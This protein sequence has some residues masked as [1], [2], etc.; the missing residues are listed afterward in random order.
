VVAKDSKGAEPVKKSIQNKDGYILITVLLMLLVLTVIGLAALG[1][2][3][4]ENL[5]S[6]NIRLKEVNFAAADG[7]NE[8]GITILQALQDD[9]PNQFSNLVTDTNL[10]TEGILDSDGPTDVT[11]MD[12][13]ETVTLDIDKINDAVPP[14]GS[15]NEFG[16]AYEGINILE[17]YY[18]IN[19]VAGNLAGSTRTVGSVYKFIHKYN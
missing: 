18:R 16:N 9:S 12:G 5:M 1:T 13:T 2:S 8:L 3:T 4:V 7:C 14:P 15:G 19:A 6:G 10:A 17:N 11:C